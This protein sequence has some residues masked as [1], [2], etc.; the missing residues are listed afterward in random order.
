MSAA[1]FALIILWRIKRAIT[2]VWAVHFST[3]ICIGNVFKL[4]I[5]EIFEASAESAAH[6]LLYLFARKP[7][8]IHTLFDH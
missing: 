7:Y 6:L 3:S 5:L 8:W 4:P 1:G 2:D